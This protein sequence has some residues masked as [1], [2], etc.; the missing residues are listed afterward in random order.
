[1]FD[2]ATYRADNK[3]NVISGGPTAANPTLPAKGT[4]IGTVDQQIGGLPVLEEAWMM[5]HLPGTQFSLK[6]GQMHD[7]LDHENIVGS[8]YRA[9]EAS[10]QGDIMGNTDTFTKAVTVL[11]N[12]GSNLRTE[13]GVNDGIRSA[14]S[15]FQEEPNN[16]HYYDYGVAGRIEYKVFGTWK[17]YGQLTSYGNSEDLLV[18]GAGVDDSNAGL[19]DE[20]SHTVDIQYA[21]KTGLFLYGSY[22]GRYTRHNTGIPNG[23][24]DSENA[25][26]A[27]PATV[28]DTYEP[29]TLFY[30]SYLVNQQWEPFGRYE[31]LHLAGT[32]AGSHNDVNEIS[33][34]L[35]Y[36][37]HGHNLKF[38]GQVMYLP[39]GIPI[40]DTS[41][42]VLA[43]NGHG[44]V[45]FIAQMQLL[46]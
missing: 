13:G 43:N 31:Y 33:L 2:W 7:P 27:P 12:N 20:L 5:Y 42:D 22:F 10:L 4:V 34:G 18:I 45:V 14:N 19:R 44:E 37:F 9:P 15:D 6:A 32:P 35:N 1:M 29:T 24:P 39:N 36:Y 40:N 17:D 38:T 26:L 30:V 41:S 28:R 25:P 21:A 8:K 46:L 11:W 16:D 3:Q 23:G